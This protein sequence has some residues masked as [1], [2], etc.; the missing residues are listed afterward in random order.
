MT[1][2]NEATVELICRDGGTDWYACAYDNALSPY[3]V[4]YETCQGWTVQQSVS[5]PAVVTGSGQ[6]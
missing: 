6:P 5:G 4:M 3:E 1:I 2:E